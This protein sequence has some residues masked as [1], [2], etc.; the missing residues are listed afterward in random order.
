MCVCVCACACVCVCERILGAPLFIQGPRSFSVPRRTI[1]KCI[2]E[3]KRNYPTLVQ[4]DHEGQEQGR[5]D[6]SKHLLKDSEGYLPC[7]Q[8]DAVRLK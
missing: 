2:H 4:P 5:G 8:V 6:D 1:N 7:I 3:E